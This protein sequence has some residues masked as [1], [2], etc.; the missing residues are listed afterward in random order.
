MS[1][2]NVMWSGGSPFTSVHKVHQQILSQTA[3]GASVKTWLLKDKAVA[4]YIVKTLSL[5]TGSAPL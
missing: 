3:P 4:A 2:I 1:I 5:M